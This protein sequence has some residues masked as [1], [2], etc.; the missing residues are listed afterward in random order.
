MTFS[1]QPITYLAQRSGW[2]ATGV[3]YNVGMRYQAKEL[4]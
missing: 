3:N 2:G 4:M 1:Q